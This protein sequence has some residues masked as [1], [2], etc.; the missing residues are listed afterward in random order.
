M[1]HVRLSC[2]EHARVASKVRQEKG[3]PKEILF[4]A[5]KFFGY[6]LEIAEALSV[7]GAIV[8]SHS[9]LP[10]SSNLVKAIVRVRREL[11][12]HY[13]NRY[14]RSIIAGLRH[15]AISHIFI[16]KG[17]TITKH[18]LL[19][20]RSAFPCARVILYLWDSI[21]NY[22]NVRENIDVV[23]KTLSF[24]PDD[25]VANSKVAFLPLFF[26]R[27]FAST[28]DYCWEDLEYDVSFVGTLHSDRLRILNE[29]E[30]RFR[31]LNL[32][33]R[34]V[35]FLR[36]PLH[37]YWGKLTDFAYQSH[38]ASD[39]VTTPVPSAAVR[40]IFF[41]SRVIVDIQHPKQQGLTM[42]TVEA[43]GSRRKLITTNASIRS[44]DF[45]YPENIRIIGRHGETLTTEFFRTPGVMVPDPIYHKYSIDGWLD[46]VFS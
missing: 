12:V 36:T 45:Y 31:K 13:T 19:M 40:D 21:K 5:P 35:Y 44:Y 6:D 4:F 25:S 22:P 1:E 34:K 10:S 16:I 33:F 41:K 14:F 43:L 27:K 17:E 37:Y 7:R 18:I 20:L 38:R 23:D 8:H 24:D 2:F 42:R 26:S 29:L 11:I 28:P 46:C 39:F 15:R 30:D 32:T 9:Y 3:S